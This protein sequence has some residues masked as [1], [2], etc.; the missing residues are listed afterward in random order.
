MSDSALTRR[1]GLTTIIVTMAVAVALL[2]TAPEASQAETPKK[3]ALVGSWLE[4]VTFP[5]ESGRPPLKSLGTF[6]DDGTMVCSDQGA[7]TTAPPSVFS[8]CHGAWTHL[9]NRTFAYTSRELISDLS[10][11]LFG[12]LKVRGVYTVS[13]SGDEYT[14]AS[15]AEIVDVDGNVLFSVSVTNAGE[16]I[17]PEV[18]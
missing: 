18:P 2:I 4:T 8:S 12:Y 13:D 16:R 5:T 3:N 1:R 6:H 14:G 9:E 7:V 10:G 15:F 17:K 11:N